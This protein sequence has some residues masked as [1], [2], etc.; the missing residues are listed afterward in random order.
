MSAVA[1]TSQT[2]RPREPSR[3]G[4]RLLAAGLT[5]VC[6][7]ELLFAFEQTHA[8][9]AWRAARDIPAPQ[10]DRLW[11]N[12][13]SSLGI[14][15]P[16]RADHADIPLAGAFSAVDPEQALSGVAFD[17]AVIRP[18]SEEPWRTEPLRIASGSEPS[19]DG[20]TFARRLRAA[21]DAQIEL[22]R[23]VDASASPLCGGQSP[24]SAAL[25]HR[26]SRVDLMLFR[27]GA[28]SLCGTWTF[29]AR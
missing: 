25:L 13:A 7:I 23:I 1:P 16:L 8:M 11:S 26:G 2:R 22:R 17:G 3:R 12:A 28:K 15:P 9:A 19:G 20:Q 18:A 21:P 5:V 14:A 10:L 4:M 29:E 24:I 6:I 27:S